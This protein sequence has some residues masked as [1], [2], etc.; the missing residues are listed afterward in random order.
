[1]LTFTAAASADSSS[2]GSL[3]E[4]TLFR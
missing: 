3:I 2:R 4:E 1:M